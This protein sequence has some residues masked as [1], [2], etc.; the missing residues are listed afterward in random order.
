MRLLYVT[1]GLFVVLIS[2]RAPQEPAALHYPEAQQPALDDA[3]AERPAPLP[4]PAHPSADRP[5]GTGLEKVN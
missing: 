2:C 1:V 5:P 3:S 4:R